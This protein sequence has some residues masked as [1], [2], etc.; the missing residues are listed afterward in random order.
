MCNML[1]HLLTSVSC[2]IRLVLMQPVLHKDIIKHNLLQDARLVLT[3]FLTEHVKSIGALY[4]DH[5]TSDKMKSELLE[6]G[7]VPIALGMAEAEPSGP[8]E[9]NY[10]ISASGER[11]VQADFV[12]TIA[13][14]M[15]DTILPDIV[16]SVW[17][18][19]DNEI[20][21]DTYLQWLTRVAQLALALAF[22]TRDKFWE[23][24]QS[25]G[26]SWTDEELFTLAHATVV[27]AWKK[28]EE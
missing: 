14:Q 21:E 19:A 28:E 13:S 7:M 15:R 24:E 4:G 22:L 9:V 5:L 12:K 26:Q 20:A 2:S 6:T 11:S 25:V 3:S 23:G 17:T 10:G 18:G 27:A 8:A 1:M 16:K